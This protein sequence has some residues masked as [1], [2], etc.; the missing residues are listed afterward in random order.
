MSHEEFTKLKEDGKHCC[1]NHWP[2]DIYCS[3]AIV[4][5]DHKMGKLCPILNIFF[6]GVGTII[7]AFFDKEHEQMNKTTLVHGVC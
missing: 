2:A 4:K 3:N 6:V 1:G 5:L 7:S